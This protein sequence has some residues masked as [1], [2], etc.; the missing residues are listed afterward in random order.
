MIGGF[1]GNPIGGVV[2]LPNGNVTMT[3]ASGTYSLTGQSALF[4]ATIG[5]YAEASAAG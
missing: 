4:K 2:N 1:I 5:P 3:V